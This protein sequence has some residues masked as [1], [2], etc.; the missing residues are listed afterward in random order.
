MWKRIRKPVMAIA[1]TLLIAFVAIQFVPVDRSNP[2]VT[3]EVPAPPEVLA[4][5]RR[6]CYDCHSN[7]VRWPWYSHVAPISWLIAKDVR[8]GRR[9]LNFSIWDQYS[10]KKQAHKIEEVHDEVASGAMPLPIYLNMH[11]EA[12]LT[13]QDIELLRAWAEATKAAPTAG[14]TPEPPSERASD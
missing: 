5:L 10:A 3:M 14:A 6:S 2:L 12:R 7:T 13:S 9:H 4:V 11:A 8:E 1:A